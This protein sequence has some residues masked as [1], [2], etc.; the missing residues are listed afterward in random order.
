MPCPRLALVVQPVVLS[1]WG[2]DG[3]GTAAI[4]PMKMMMM[5]MMMMMMPYVY[6]LA[7][8]LVVSRPHFI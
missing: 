6:L 1:P 3:L 7:P 4:F 2:L 5:M 8:S